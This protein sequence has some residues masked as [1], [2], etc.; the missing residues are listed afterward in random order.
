MTRRLPPALAILGLAAVLWVVPSVGTQGM[1]T[2]GQR[3]THPDSV[4]VDPHADSERERVVARTTLQAADAAT[5]A[6]LGF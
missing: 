1:G 4:L 6:A 5:E 2:I 3:F